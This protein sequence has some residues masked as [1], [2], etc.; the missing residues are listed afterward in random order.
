MP[1]HGRKPYQHNKRFPTVCVLI[2]LLRGVASYN[3]ILCTLS[4]VQDGGAPYEGS[5]QIQPCWK[6]SMITAAT[7]IAFRNPALN[8]R[9]VNVLQTN[10]QASCTA[11]QRPGNT[12]CPAWGIQGITQDIAAAV[13]ANLPILR[14]LPCSVGPLHTA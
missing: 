8:L 9:D 3:F 2:L 14:L 4:N 13:L 5:K 10:Q 12:F 7:D 1:L 11:D 6:L